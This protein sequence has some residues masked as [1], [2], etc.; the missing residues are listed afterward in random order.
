LALASTFERNAWTFVA[1]VELEDGSGALD[2]DD[3]GLWR[4]TT[5]TPLL[6]LLDHAVEIGIAGAKAARK[7][8]SPALGY[9]LAIG[10]DLELTGAPRLSD[11]LN[12]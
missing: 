10:E 7:P 4:R 5:P 2:R 9:F 8:V 3:V 6:E 12:T 1:R 11:S